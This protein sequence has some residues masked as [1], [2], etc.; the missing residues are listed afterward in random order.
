MARAVLRYLNG[1]PEAKDTLD[2][3]AR[4]WLQ[5][6]WTERLL[7]DV[8]QALAILMS[9]HLVLETRRPGTP[10]C[11]RLNAEQGE[12]IVKMLQGRGRHMGIEDARGRS[13]GRAGTRARRTP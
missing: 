7:G 3:I 12:A 5:R 1:H 10:P 8:E 13:R 11:Y 6:E 9:R 2:G 4:W